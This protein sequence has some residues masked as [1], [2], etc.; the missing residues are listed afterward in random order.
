MKDVIVQKNN[1]NKN[2]NKFVKMFTTL[3][4]GEWRRRW[5]MDKGVKIG[6]N[7]KTLTE[8]FFLLLLDNKHC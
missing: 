5:G 2:K 8:Q 1:N 6:A 3:L 4:R 7:Y